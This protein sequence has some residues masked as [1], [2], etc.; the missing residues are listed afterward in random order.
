MLPRDAIL[1]ADAGAHLAWLGYCVELEEGQNFRKCGAFE[2]M[3]GHTNA[4]TGVQMAHPARTVVVGCGDGCYA[5]SGFELMTAVE[6]DAPDICVVFN[7][8]ST[9][10]SSC[11]RS[12]RT[13]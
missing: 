1:L 3:A 13:A 2:P 10:S 11:T 4:A 8:S 12:P 9:R 7:V 6:H 5:M